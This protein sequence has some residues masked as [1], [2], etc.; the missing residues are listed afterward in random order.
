V[1][2]QKTL[3]DEAVLDVALGVMFAKGLGD[4]TLADVSAVCGM[5]P[6]T[7]VQRFGG[8]HELIVRAI[9]QDNQTFAK[10]LSDLPPTPGMAGVIAIF[11][12]L[13]PDLA[14]AETLADQLLWL[15]LDIRDPALN[16]LARERF[17]LLRA[18]VAGRMAHS[19]FPGPA[20]AKLIEAQW[21]GALNQWAIRPE[22]RLGDYVTNS[23]AAWFAMSGVQ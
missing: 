7:L 20:L 11:R 8:K 23:L 3:S 22:G 13:T 19:R 12:L 14:E 9:A 21:Q 15:R 18:A 6:A 16:A 2:R 10:A 4:F 5:A 1:P 17:T